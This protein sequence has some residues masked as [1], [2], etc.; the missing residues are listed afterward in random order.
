LTAIGQHYESINEFVMAAAT[1]SLLRGGAGALLDL[2][3]LDQ[4]TS[5]A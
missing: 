2:V 1:M 5:D 3:V 4:D